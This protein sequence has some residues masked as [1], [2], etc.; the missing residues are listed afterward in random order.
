MADGRAKLVID[1]GNSETRVMTIYGRT[2]EGLPRYILSSLSN[3]FGPLEPNYQIADEYDESNTKIFKMFGGSICTGEL[4]NREFVNSDD[5]RPSAV[6][7]KYN[8]D[9]TDMTLRVALLQGYMDIAA[10]EDIP[11]EDVDVDWD[12]VTMLPPSDI[13]KGA[14]KMAEKIK[15]IKEIEFSMPVFKT[16]VNI[17]N[18]RIYPEGF[19]AYIGILFDMN[20]KLR[21]EYKHLRK[22][23]AIIFDI[24]A[25]TTDIS[26]I[27][28]GKLVQATRFTMQIGGNNVHQRVRS[29]LLADGLEL[30]DDIVKDA[31]ERGWIKDGSKK[32][33]ITTQIGEAKNQVSRTIVSN[34]R[35]FFE[36]T[37]YPIKKIE[38]M[39]VCGG[40]AVDSDIAGIHPLSEYLIQYMK[41]LSENIS[42]VDLP[43]IEKDGEMEVLSPRVLNI[44]GAGVLALGD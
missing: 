14:E 44:Y 43:K 29:M 10:M 42:L 25:G 23:T 4:C 20:R 38:Q 15:G 22:E 37:Q 27:E 7:K 8:S 28:E 6:E 36:A 24:G 2:W 21:S 31:V 41:K 1:L 13:A 12:I 40:G 19:C 18:V 16:K 17:V 9:V 34:V 3:H 26:I 32:V 30:P 5:F 39:I 35:N 11:L 33:S